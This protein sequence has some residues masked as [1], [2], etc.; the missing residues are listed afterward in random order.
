MP[1]A[2]TDRPD[3]FGRRESTVGDMEEGYYRGISYSA[4]VSDLGA[5]L[6]WS[7]SG[8]LWVSDSESSDAAAEHIIA[9]VKARGGQAINDSEHSCVFLLMPTAQDARVV[10]DVLHDQGRVV[11]RKPT[12]QPRTAA[13]IMADLVEVLWYHEGAM[14]DHAE[15][16][17]D[18]E[19]EAREFI[20]REGV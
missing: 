8:E 4:F 11:E 9:E 2:Y 18:L 20:K 19:A 10:I 15:R 7:V 5:A 3:S 17:H 13:A 14:D 6:P 16:I 1:R 12:P